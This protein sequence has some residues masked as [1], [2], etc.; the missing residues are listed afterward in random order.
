[1]AT[2]NTTTQANGDGDL[3]TADGDV[4]YNDLNDGGGD[5]STADGDVWDKSGD[6]RDNEDYERQL[7]RLRR[8]DRLR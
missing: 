4:K 3:S 6:N 2:S 5:Y 8:A 1:M 7:P